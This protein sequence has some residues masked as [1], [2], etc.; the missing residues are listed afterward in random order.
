MLLV[1]GA[2]VLCV[3]LLAAVAL[4]GLFVWTFGAGLARG[5]GALLI[6]CDLW[7]L[8]LGLFVP[9]VLGSAALWLAVGVALWL[10]GHWVHIQRCGWARSALA[11]RVFALPGLRALVPSPAGYEPESRTGG[12]GVGSG[13]GAGAAPHRGRGW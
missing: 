10:V 1:F 6:V 9:W 8:M 13:G 12:T 2:V 4:L 11:D 7:R 3:S 5:L